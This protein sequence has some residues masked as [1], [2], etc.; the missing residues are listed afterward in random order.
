MSQSNVNLADGAAQY[1]TFFVEQEEYAVHILRVKEILRYESIT[2]VPTAPS[3]IRGVINVR[4]NVVPV[5]DLGI[6]F[7]LGE[8]QVT[9]RTCIVL[10]DVLVEDE[11]AVMGVMVD[12]VSQVVELSKA[13][14]EPPPAFGAGIRVEYLVG[15]AKIGQRF[16]LML[17]IDRVLSSAELLAADTARQAGETEG[18][19]VEE[20]AGAVS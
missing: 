9:P 20:M 17:D 19:E 4:G 6:K 13:D 1:L 5:I 12:A 2:R 10:I 8:R 11:G 3:F 18:A 15:M 7:G 14:V 16:A